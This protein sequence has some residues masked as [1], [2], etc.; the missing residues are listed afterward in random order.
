MEVL[1]PSFLSLTVTRTYA[2]REPS[3][4]ICGSPTQLKLK[5]SF[6]VMLR[7]CANAGAAQEAMAMK[8]AKTIDRIEF[9][10]FGQTD[11]APGE[12]RHSNPSLEVKN[13][14]AGSCFFS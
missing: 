13:R 4:E 1:Y 12:R 2:T 11:C 10:F 7:F 9:P 5:R 8:R 6:S 14:T 3:G